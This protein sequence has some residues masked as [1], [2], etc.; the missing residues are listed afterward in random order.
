MRP[1]DLVADFLGGHPEY[2]SMEAAVTAAIQRGR[3]QASAG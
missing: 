2:A 1:D 3:E